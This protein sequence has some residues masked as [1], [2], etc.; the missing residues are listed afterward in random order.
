MPIPNNIDEAIAQI[1]RENPRLNA[2]VDVVTNSNR[3]VPLQAKR[4][5]PV[6][7]SPSKTERQCWTLAVKS[8]IAV[9]GLPHTAGIGAYQNRIANEDA[10]CVARLRAADMIIVGMANMEEAALGAVTHNPHFGKTHHPLRHGFTAG[11]S[12]GGSAAAV[13]AGM[14]RAALGTD[15]MG[16]C[17]IP[18]AYCGVVG[19]KPSFGRISVRGVTPLSRRLDHVGVIAN[20]VA[21]VR[22]V[23]SIISVFD[24]ACADSRVFDAINDVGKKSTW[25]RLSVLDATARAALSIGVRAAYEHALAT[26]KHVGFELTERALNLDAITA[27]RRAGLIICEAELAN[28]LAEVLKS[29]GEGVSPFLRDMIAFGAAKSAPQLAAAHARIDDAELILRTQLDGV[30]AIFWPTAPQTAFAFSAPV[31]ANQADFTCLA[32]FTGAPAISVPARVADGA[33]PV[34]LQLIS[35]VGSDDELL[36]LA[37]EIESLLSPS[38]FNGVSA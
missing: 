16:S 31:P 4:L 17:R 18:A 27:A 2:L 34:G 3:G 25:R 6:R 33:L 29:G 12:S 37:V 28:S 1:Q 24:A 5:A 32:N 20:T 35:P 36:S 9:D 13:A 30:D 19:F 14:A 22:V 7:V 21:D 26:L 38:P 8:N 23:A 10:F 15:T 11:G